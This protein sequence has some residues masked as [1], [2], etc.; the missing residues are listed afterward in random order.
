M[1]QVCHCCT[2]S[3]RLLIDRQLVEGVSIAQVSRSFG[4]PYNSVFNHKSHIS[5]QLTQV[6]ARQETIHNFNLLEKIDQI[7][8]RAEDLFQRNYDKGRDGLALKALAES[9]NTV[10]L[11]AKISF[12]LEQTRQ[13][14]LELAR[15]QSG[16]VTIELQDDFQSK[17]SV[18][19]SAELQVLVQLQEKLETGDSTIVVIPEI[20]PNA[21]DT[22]SSVYK[23]YA[24]QG[25]HRTRPQTQAKRVRTTVPTDTTDT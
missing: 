9:R 5:R 7:I 2:N 24:T 12:Q 14:E 15:I 21:W 18:L 6:L 19:N 22:G 25:L 11:L 1:P 8:L 17:L 16:E 23:V 10:E 3:Q 20:T 13:A 4:I